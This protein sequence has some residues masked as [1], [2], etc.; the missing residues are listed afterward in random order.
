MSFG[1]KK[2]L[3]AAS[4]LIAGPA[5]GQSV[6]Q[7][8]TVTAKH[9]A[10]WVTGG[11]IGDGGSSAS[12]PISSFGVTNNGGSGIC[13]N[14]ALPTAAGYQALCLGANTTGPATISLQNFGT[15]TPQNL[16]FVV[17]GTPVIIPTGGNNFLIQSGTPVSGHVPCY[18][19]TV[20]IVV[21]C[22]TSIGSGTQFG[23]PY[24]ST[25][26]SLGS[27]GAGTNGQFLIG[28][29]SSVP[30]WASLSGDVTSVS[31][32]G[33]LTLGKVNGIPFATTYSANGVLI[34]EGTN[35]FHSVS[36]LNIG[37]CLLSQGA[38]DPIWS[39][40]AAGSGSAGGSNTQVQ[41]NNSTSLGGSANLTW[42]SPTLTIG[43]AGATTGQLGLAS[44]TATGTV[45]L[46]APGVSTSYNFNFPTGAGSSGQPLLSGGGGSTPNTFG[47][48]NIGGGGTDCATASG[49][50][51]DNI[52]GFSST[53]FVQRTGS[54]SYAFS[55]VVPVSGGGTGLA[56][57]TSG[58]I[59]AYTGA[60]TIASSGVLA[61]YG[62][63]VG[64]GAG[65]TPATVSNG[66]AGQLLV[67]QTSANPA[68]NTLSG[69]ATINSSGAIT[70]A[71]G[72]I[73]LAKQANAAAYSLEGNF[74]SG[75]AA[76]Q[77]STIGGL[78]QKA[79][80]AANDY[81]M[82]QDNAASGQ[83]KYATI[84]SVASAGSVA[85]VNGATGAVTV[86][87][88]GGERV[89][90]SGA[91][92]TL[93]SPGGDLN[94]FRNPAMDIFQ[95]GTSATT[96]S[97]SGSYFADG[98]RVLFTG[99]ATVTAQQTGTNIN[100]TN[101]GLSVTGATSNTDIKVGQR[102]ESYVAAPLQGQTVTVQ[103]AYRQNTGSTQTPKVSSCYAS[104]SDN[105]ATCTADLAATSLTACA[106]ATWCTESYT[107]TASANAYFGYE[108]DFD[109]NAAFTAS[110]SCLITAA[111]IR[112]TPGVATGINANPPPPELRP[113][114]IEMALNQRY[115]W[116]NAPGV[117]FASLAAGQVVNA[118]LA[119]FHLQ[120]PVPM[121]SPPTLAISNT[122]VASN[123]AVSAT[124]TL[125]AT[126]FIGGS[127]AMI[128]VDG[129][130][131]GST[132]Q[133]GN[134]LAGTTAGFISASSE[135]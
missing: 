56:N 135:L 41:F 94:K 77:F 103:F 40:C 92:V 118:T 105:F 117:Q 73:T 125:D 21:D 60:S 86:A 98:W 115:F 55:L 4:L 46:Q 116:Q 50:C 64:G 3:V 48:L 33:A 2:F 49:T 108:V 30:L 88:A 84:A 42:A 57:G 124:V 20:G 16:E 89:T 112:V 78:T 47:T 75:S 61:Q 9:V 37:Q 12:S 119:E 122:A 39:S 26:S 5:F 74:T 96:I 107:F 35:A 132:G 129:T 6:Q 23:L 101:W 54:G 80:P 133:G 25:A 131:F 36:T 114:G 79:S 15:A 67:A 113:I 8:G 69:D 87:A 65:S 13:V 59:P 100:G 70:V 58:G 127:S 24:Y 51:L 91:T 31:A 62:I 76:P 52:T 34:G 10:A 120:Y 11:V 97:T 7:S 38:S 121:R 68:W 134:L 1:M 53:G 14:S 104:A 19:G 44:S 43:V 71:A 110:T 83:I 130:A 85:T 111:D 66:V 128:R 28:Q 126:Q 81:L 45:T 106:T 123:G 109:C 95:R 93:Y 32:G 29:T 63:V 18:S 27:T 102:I 82:V 90:T 72:A 99:S 22:G 17:N